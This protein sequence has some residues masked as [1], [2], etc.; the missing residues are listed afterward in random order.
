MHAIWFFPCEQNLSGRSRVHREHGADGDGVTK[1]RH[2]F[3]SS[4]AHALVALAAVQLS[5]FASRVTQGVQRG[6]GGSEKFVLASCGREFSNACAEN[7]A[8]VHIASHQ[9]VM[10]QCA[11]ES[12][13][14]RTSKS[15]R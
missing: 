7:E 12:V 13:S 3:G 1:T 10:L 14:G 4:N 11:C 5:A 2:A 9:T 15:R 6:V 8:A